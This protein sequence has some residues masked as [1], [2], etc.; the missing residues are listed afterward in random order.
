MDNNYGEY[1]EDQGIIIHNI[2]LKW[3]KYFDINK[4][5]SFDDFIS[6]LEANTT[7][8]VRLALV[9]RNQLINQ[10]SFFYTT[11]INKEYIHLR[12]TYLNRARK[13]KQILFSNAF[14]KFLLNVEKIKNTKQ[15]LHVSDELE[16]S[17]DY[18]Y[19]SAIELFKKL[20]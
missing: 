4:S 5:R 14:K 19:N 13:S 17:I 11:C 16:E 15:T 7:I 20:Q 3:L 1:P 8:S 10:I 18:T 6:E 9:L 12:D 2:V